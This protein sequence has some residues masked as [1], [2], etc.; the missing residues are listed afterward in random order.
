[1]VRQ[2]Q[3][4]ARL[5]VAATAWLGATS[6]GCS[7]DSV[8]PPAESPALTSA[9][10]QTFRFAPP[11]GTRFTRHDRRRE[12]RA[13]VGTP[14]RA[15]QEDELQWKVAIDKKD[16]GY[17]IRQDLVRIALKRDGAVLAEGKVESGIS[18]ELVI[19]RA[20][21]LTE[22]KGLD[23][24]AEHLRDLAAPGMQA[25]VERT[26]TPDY[27][28]AVVANRYRLLFGETV[29]R[30][31]TPGSSW[32]VT[33]PP[34]SFVA[35]RKVTV[36]RMEPCGSAT[37]ARMRVDFNVDS[38]IMAGTAVSL[39]KERVQSIG[40]D[41]SKVTV[42]SASYGM[43][44]AMLTEPATMLSHGASFLETGRVTLL[45]HSQEQV[46]VE[47]KGTTEIA[48]AYEPSTVAALR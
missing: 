45:D 1:M 28:T 20:G 9:A 11:D 8:T 41:P 7:K 21:N 15:V 14:V 4:L 27:L 12:E 6:V 37:C 33:N 23:K 3:H 44:G 2:L 31:A 30:Q 47:V 29:G 25:A 48:Y 22:V 24:T 40:G 5:G 17:H 36:E 43:S 18:A 38:R 26:L 35:S 34:G 32:T 13:I 10:T 19:D 46:T 16:D 39:V 42:R